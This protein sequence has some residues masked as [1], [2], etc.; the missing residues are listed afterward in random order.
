M[1]ETDKQKAYE[2]LVKL[3]AHF[4]GTKHTADKLKVS[5]RTAQNWI[6]E[7]P[8]LRSL[9]NLDVCK[10][11]ERMTP[12]KADVYRPDLDLVRTKRGLIDYGRRRAIV[13][14]AES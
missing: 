3:V 1:N 7:N 10:A 4:G 14:G 5:Q 9:P 6:A 11:I 12:F 2:A 8:D 13:G